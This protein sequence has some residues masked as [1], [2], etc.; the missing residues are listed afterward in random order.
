MCVCDVTIYPT[1]CIQEDAP[2]SNFYK[3][4]GMYFYKVA[5]LRL[6]LF[7][8]ARRGLTVASLSMD[9]RCFSQQL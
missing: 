5:T 3:P 2:K 1:T 8:M 4:P 6:C 7:S 9:N